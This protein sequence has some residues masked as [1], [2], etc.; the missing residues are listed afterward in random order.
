MNTFLAYNEEINGRWRPA[1][2]A[3]PGQRP[4]KRPPEWSPEMKSKWRSKERS[5]GSRQVPETFCFLMFSH[6]N[7]T[8]RALEMLRKGVPKGDQ[9]E[10]RNG[11]KMD[12][13]AWSPTARPPAEP[14]ASLV[15]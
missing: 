13:K 14:A 11:A 7:G 12:A 6:Q 1:G 10:T 15:S 4:P 3:G 8:D 5:F 9:Q 2:P